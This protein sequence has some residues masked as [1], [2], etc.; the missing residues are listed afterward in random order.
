M[1]RTQPA[2]KK[3]KE[4]E[5]NVLTSL[6]QAQKTTNISVTLSKTP[7]VGIFEHVRRQ[8]MDNR[9]TVVTLLIFIP[10]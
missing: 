2:Q 6:Y 5:K 1:S 8:V 7:R 9:V 4:N 3:D 10:P